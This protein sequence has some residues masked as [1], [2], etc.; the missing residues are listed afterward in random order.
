MKTTKRKTATKRTTTKKPTV[1]GLKKVCSSVVKATGLKTDG[2]L[3]KGFKYVAGGKI[4]KVVAK[5]APVR[6]KVVKKAPVKKA[7]KK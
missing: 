3:K 7:K 2:T 1:R 4:V 6:K 5:K